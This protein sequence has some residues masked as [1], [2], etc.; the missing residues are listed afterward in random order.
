M[1]QMGQSEFVLSH[2]FAL[3]RKTAEAV[4]FSV[5]VRVVDPLSR[6]TKD[7][8]LESARLSRNAKVNTR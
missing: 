6:T 4:R 5:Q 7:N 3:F 2:F 1:L 8:L